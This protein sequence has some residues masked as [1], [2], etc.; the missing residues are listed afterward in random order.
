MQNINEILEWGH[1]NLK[2][3]YLRLAEEITAAGKGSATLEKIKL[4][5]F[6]FKTQGFVAADVSNHFYPSLMESPVINA[7]MLVTTSTKKG[8]LR[9]YTEEY[10]IGTLDKDPAKTSPTMFVKDYKPSSSKVQ[11]LEKLLMAR[12]Y[13]GILDFMEVEKGVSWNC[14]KI[15]SLKMLHEMKLIEEASARTGNFLDFFFQTLDLLMN[16]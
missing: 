10:D 13:Q 4:L 3:P 1:H 14:L 7:V 6:P 11:E 16:L 8:I 5:F 15:G 9:I 2:L 12:N